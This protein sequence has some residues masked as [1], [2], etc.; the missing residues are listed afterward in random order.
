MW[1]T[2]LMLKNMKNEKA[3]SD[4]QFA[5]L[6]RLVKERDAVVERQVAAA[7]R[8]QWELAEIEGAKAH[9]LFK[10]IFTF[11]NSCKRGK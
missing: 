3:M 6:L 7:K 8:K 2:V 5:Q 11:C 10:G 1:Y 4:E 9:E